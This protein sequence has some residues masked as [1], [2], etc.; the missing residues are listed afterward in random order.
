LLGYLLLG[1]VYGIYNEGLFGKTFFQSQIANTS[2]NNYGIVWD[3]NLTWA[4]VIIVFHAF[5]AFLFPLLIV[6]NLFPKL[7]STS[8]LD[9]KVWLILSIICA[10]YIFNKFLGNPSPATPLHYIVLV[11]IMA[12]LTLVS[13]SF[14]G[15]LHID[16]K[17]PKLWLIAYGVVFVAATF[18]VADVIARSRVNYLFFLAYSVINFV[19]AATLL[20]KRYGIRT[21]LIFSLSAQFGFAASVILVAVMTK[22]ETGIVT[23]SVFALVFAATLIKILIKGNAQPRKYNQPIGL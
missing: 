17:K 20:D 14:K 16:A 23:G 11:A 15:G 12:I 19:I 21:L 4:A 22:S 3:I 8:W 5:Y 6:Y 9:K 18:T 7:A 10:L 1:L 2:F 13:G